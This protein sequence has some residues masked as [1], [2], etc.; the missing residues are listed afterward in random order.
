MK[1]AGRRCVVE[2]CER[3]VQP[4]RVL[5]AEHRETG[6]GRDVEAALRRV[7]AAMTRAVGEQERAAAAKGFWR[8]VARGDHGELFDEALREAT[9]QATEERGLTEEIGVLRL[10][11]MRLL[12]E[13][14]DA[15]TLAREVSRLT[16]RSVRAVKRREEIK[17]E[18]GDEVV[19]AVRRMVENGE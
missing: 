16:D 11:M 7:T 2:G 10:A 12:M 17:G 5:C 1:G 13:E 14:G 8:R 3:R 4:G 18:V 9:A 19:G 6:Y 15:V